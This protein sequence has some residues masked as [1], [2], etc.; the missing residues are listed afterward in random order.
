MYKN[1]IE[2]EYKGYRFRSR[3][4]AR[5]AVF[6]DK[7]GLEWEYEPEGFN[8]SNGEKY[9]PDFYF[10]KMDW[11]CEV[12][13]DRPGAEKEIQNKTKQLVEDLHVAVLLLSS[14]PEVKKNTI[15]TFPVLYYDFFS[16]NHV[17]TET[18]ALLGA[19][20]GALLYKKFDDC[21]NVSSAEFTKYLEKL[22]EA[23]KAA[24]QARFEFGE[25][26]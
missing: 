21:A 7:I 22:N 10:P 3:L 1:P 20:Q 19:E 24:R 26:G 25:S 23:Y 2:T 13:P 9:L 17:A 12:K 14:L 4:E 15:W 16:Q 11:Y 5:W 6:F 18:I 8:L